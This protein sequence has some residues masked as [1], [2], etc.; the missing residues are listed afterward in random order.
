VLKVV[1]AGEQ[2]GRHLQGRIQQ[3]VVGEGSLRIDYRCA[4]AVP[5][6]VSNQWMTTGASD[7]TQTL[8]RLRSLIHYGAGS[9]AAA[10]TV[11]AWRWPSDL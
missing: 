11:M 8:R 10:S 4:S 1:A 7:H 6:G 2:C 5:L 3:S 9:A